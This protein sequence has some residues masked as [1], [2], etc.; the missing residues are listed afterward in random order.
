MSDKVQ[1]PLD[2]DGNSLAE[3]STM[4]EVVVARARKT[5]C[6]EAGNIIS[7]K[8]VMPMYWFFDSRI[9]IPVNDD[10]KLHMTDD[11]LCSG[12]MDQSIALGKRLDKA[13]NTVSWRQ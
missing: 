13:S 10:G 2:V 9:K 5:S 11:F 8:E 1:T 4:Y 6:K 7:G 3:I 12:P